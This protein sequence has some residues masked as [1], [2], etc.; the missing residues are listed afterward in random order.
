M[1]R[2][3]DDDGDEELNHVEFAIIS[4]VLRCALFLLYGPICDDGDEELNHIEFANISIV[5]RC[6]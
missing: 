5:L 1:I 6:A 3:Y 4:I 2:N